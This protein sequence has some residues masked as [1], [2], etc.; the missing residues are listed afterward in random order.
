MEG[1]LDLLF[2]ILSLFRHHVV[3]VRHQ[4][5]LLLLHLDVKDFLHSSF[6]G[7]TYLLDALLVPLLQARDVA[8]ALLGLLD[9]LP[10]LHLLLLEKGDSVGKQLSVSLDAD[11]VSSWEYLLFA[12]LLHVSEGSHLPIISLLGRDIA[13][14]RH[15]H[16][17]LGFVRRVGRL[18]L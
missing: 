6:V 12:T 14:L 16:R 4:S 7:S 1:V 11:G 15:L 13:G 8:R 3:V 10:R 18:H 5:L 17:D 2:L 9:L